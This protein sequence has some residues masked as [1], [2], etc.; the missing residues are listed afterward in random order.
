MR[1]MGQVAALDGCL[2]RGCVG[3]VAKLRASSEELV[4]H[5]RAKHRLSHRRSGEHVETVDQ[6]LPF[7]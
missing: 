2:M 3:N 7:G 4:K 1:L 5:P 6:D